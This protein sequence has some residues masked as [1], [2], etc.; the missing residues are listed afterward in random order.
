MLVVSETTRQTERLPGLTV[1]RALAEQPCAV[2]YDLTGGQ[3]D[4]TTLPSAF[5]AIDAYLR[6]CDGTPLLVC[7]ETLTARRA[8][9]AHPLNTRVTRFPT[10]DSAL[11]SAHQQPTAD[12]HA[13]ELRSTRWAPSRARQFVAPLL[14][15][16]RLPQPLLDDA[17]LVISEL[18]TNVVLHAPTLTSMTLTVSRTIPHAAPYHPTLRLAVRDAD[19]TL[20]TLRT[21][22]PD[23][24]DGRGLI[25]VDR[26]VRAWGAIPLDIGKIVWTV[27]DGTE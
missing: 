18:V 26:L 10:L 6:H 22:S 17:A 12:K 2:V 15:G 21:P 4:S 19:D 23:N 24:L 20:P 9:R 3:I 1:L 11:V 7:P 14:D 27:F 5:D 13:L 25:I 16:W 8:L